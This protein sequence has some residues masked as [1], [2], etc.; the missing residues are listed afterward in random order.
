MDLGPV[1][2]C[3]GV[4]MTR[5]YV[6]SLLAGAALEDALETIVARA[7]Q[8]LLGVDSAGVAVHRD[9]AP[10]RAA[11]SPLARQVDDVQY[12][13]GQGPCL[14]AFHANV[15]VVLDLDGRDR[16]WTVFQAAALASGARTVLSVPLRLD[17]HPIGSLNLYS[18][19]RRAFSA[20]VVREAELFARPAGL[21]LSRAGVAVHAV[22][23]A[24]VAGLELQDRTVIDR[25]LGVLMGVHDDPSVERAV[26]R[27]EQVAADL[28][29]DVPLAAAR[30]VA[31]PPVTPLPAPRGVPWR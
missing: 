1:V 10:V 23:A 4:V 9:R 15:V 25:A 16:R 24:E 31:A 17:G 6:E 3:K 2:V 21:F 19:G 22:E 26:V 14:Q 11:S 27:L 8:A 28:G 5:V 7:E 20:R 13:I 29:L 18:R 12:R 30:I